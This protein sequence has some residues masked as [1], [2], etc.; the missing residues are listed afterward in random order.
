MERFEKTVEIDVP[1]RTAY[2]QFT[3]FEDF[4][5]FMYGVVDVEQ[6][7]DTHLHWRVS[8]AGKELEW[9]VEILEQVPDQLIEWDGTSDPPNAG[10][11][12]FEALPGE[13]T[14][15]SLEM[16]YELETGTENEEYAVCVVSSSIGKALEDFKRFIEQRGAE[17]GGWR[18]EVHGGQVTGPAGIG[19][20]EEPF[21]GG[22]PLAPG[23]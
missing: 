13:R 15:L 2:N 3:Q 4:P 22:E 18:G 10:E 20:P 1:V 8:V 9:D 6:L 11:V 16:E 17:T 12:R 14:R 19:T 5:N 23:A 7:D 21:P